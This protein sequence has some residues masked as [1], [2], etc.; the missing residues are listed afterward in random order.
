GCPDNIASRDIDRDGISDILDSCPEIPEIYNKFQDDDGCPD[1]VSDTGIGYTFPDTDDDGIQDRWDSCITEPENINGQ[2]DWDGCPEIPGVTSQEAMDSDYDSIPDATDSCPQDRENFN[3]FQDD[4]GCPDVVDYKITGDVDGDAILDHNDSCPFNPE[5]YNKFQ[6]DDGCPDHIADDK[7]T[8]D[9][10]NDG[11]LDDK[12]KVKGNNTLANTNIKNFTLKISDKDNLSEAFNKTE[13]VKFADDNKPRLE[14]KFNFT[15][16]VLDLEKIIVETKQDGISGGMFVSGLELE[17]GE[18]KTFYID[19]LSISNEICIKDAEIENLANITQACNEVNET[20]LFCPGN[21]SAPSTGSNYRCE[22]TVINSTSVNNSN[23]KLYKISG[24][25]NSG[26]Q[27][28]ANCIEQ[29]SCSEWTSC[30]SNRQA[31]AC[32]DAKKCGTTTAM[33]ALEQSCGIRDSDSNGRSISRSGELISIGILENGAMKSVE[34]MRYDRVRF[35]MDNNVYHMETE[36][37]GKSNAEISIKP[38]YAN[39]DLQLT[40]PLKL[41]LNDN[42][43][44]DIII[45]LTN[46][47][48]NKATFSLQNLNEVIE[49]EQN[50]NA[51]ILLRK[52]NRTITTPDDISIVVQNITIAKKD[53]K[54][55]KKD[56]LSL[57]GWALLGLA[58]LTFIGVLTYVTSIQGKKRSE[59]RKWAI[60]K[61]YMEHGK[62]PPGLKQEEH[63]MYLQH[64]LYSQNKQANN[65]QQKQV[66]NQQY[67]EQ[68]QKAAE[69]TAH[70]EVLAMFINNLKEKNY[71][72]E[73]IMHDLV[74]RGWN[75][76]DV[77]HAIKQQESKQVYSNIDSLVAF[78]EDAFQRGYKHDQ[79]AKSL[80]SKGW[81]KEIIMKVFREEKRLRKYLR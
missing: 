44:N 65:V 33:P 13:V 8:A 61:Y 29:W 4:D 43:I 28:L 26:V 42:G 69:K 71:S 55:I 59:K 23:I 78:I 30:S 25:R 63:Q 15:N 70:H 56:N 66:K 27:E 37:I 35:V 5:T 51:L 12:D 62:L 72:R 58:I 38:G 17:K 34:I 74:K 68:V 57:K 64:K 48:E 79:I 24:L 31:R 67:T 6:D 32:N 80:H 9:T 11:I 52:I 16:K 1:T 77:E 18:T 3:K 20:L 53:I 75:P 10:D 41:D 47:N 60:E 22:N 14:F 73:Q 50:L 76:R 46:I 39:V 49:N 40:T 19:D 45:I 7:F 36:L 2:L 21:F 81:P 54:D